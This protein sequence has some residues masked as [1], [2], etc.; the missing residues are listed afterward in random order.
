MPNYLALCKTSLVEAYDSPLIVSLWQDA[1]TGQ[2]KSKI[3]AA[4][5]NLA[6]LANQFVLR[7]ARD[8]PPNE[9]R[10][11]SI[12]N[13]QRTSLGRKSRYSHRPRPETL[14]LCQTVSGHARS[15]RDKWSKLS[16]EIR[17]TEMLD[18]LDHQ[19]QANFI[20]TNNGFERSLSRAQKAIELALSTPYPGERETAF[21]LAIATLKRL[22]SFSDSEE[23]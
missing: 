11:L 7:S 1:A 9:E 20:E 14:I 3:Q 4:P 21:N 17:A 16:L 13:W 5:S 12:F 8:I 23:K 6:Q 15:L 2:T 18:L 10:I 19:I 22:T